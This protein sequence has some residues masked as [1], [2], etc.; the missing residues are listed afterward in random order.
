MARSPEN[1][2]PAPEPGERYD[3]IYAP[4]GALQ[5]V[6]L[7]R[8]LAGGKWRMLSR[9]LGLGIFLFGA[10]LLLWV[11]WQALTGFQYL[12]KSNYLS[13]QFNN[14]VTVAGDGGVGP[15]VQAAIVVFGTELLKV[16]Y[17]LLLGFL[18]SIIASKGIQFFAASEAI[19]DEAVVGDVQP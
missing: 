10:V 2:T 15:Q 17:L 4:Q 19:I 3:H 6:A 18:A 5:E 7:A 1:I 14:A 11:F 16:L 8:F 13:S 9:W 12:M